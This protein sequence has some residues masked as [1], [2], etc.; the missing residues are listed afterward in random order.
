MAAR[1]IRLSRDVLDGP[2]GRSASS[3]R[4][5]EPEADTGPS[6]SFGVAEP[7]IPWSGDDDRVGVFGRFDQVVGDLRDM[8]C[9][10][11]RRFKYRDVYWGSVFPMGGGAEWFQGSRVLP[12]AEILDAIRRD[13]FAALADF[14]ELVFACRLAGISMAIT[15][16][17]AGGGSTFTISSI[18]KARQRDEDSP[19]TDGHQ[20]VD[21]YTHRPAWQTGVRVPSTDG[22]DEFYWNHGFPD[23]HEET[24]QRFATQVWPTRP[25]DPAPSTA[26]SRECA[27]RKSLGVAAFCQGI[28]EHLEVLNRV[29]VRLLGNEGIT[30]VVTH[31]E[32]GNEL[33]GSFAVTPPGDAPSYDAVAASALEAGQFMVLLAQPFR[34]L[35]PSMRFRAAELS[36]WHPDIASGD[37]DRC[38]P[39]A[40]CCVTDTYAE[41]VAWLREAIGEGVTM[42]H[43]VQVLNQHS[44]AVFLRTGGEVLLSEDSI[45]WALTCIEAGYAW[46]PFVTEVSDVLAFGATSLVH[47][48]GFHWFH[49]YDRDA[50][51]TEAIPKYQD[52]IRIK[53]DIDLLSRVVV[54]ALATS[55][56]FAL[57]MTVG[58]VGFP[59]VFPDGIPE[60]D[61][62]APYYNY[63]NTLLQAGMLARYLCLFQ[64][65]GVSRSTWFCTY[66]QP[67]PGSAN[68]SPIQWNKEGVGTGLHND[69]Y[70]QKLP[71]EYQNFAARGAWRRPAWFTYRRVA[72]LLSL[73]DGP[74]TLFE[75]SEGRTVLRFRLRTRLSLRQDVSLG[76]RYLWVAWVDQYADSECLHGSFRLFSVDHPGPVG[77]STMSMWLRDTTGRGYDLLSLVPHVTELNIRPGESDDNGYRQ[78]SDRDWN[79]EGWDSA[80]LDHG[81]TDVAFTGEKLSWFFIRKC[82]TDV[83]QAPVAIL[84]DAEEAWVS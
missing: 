76:Y 75:N 18:N 32:L 45:E 8:G 33:N 17:D 25:S 29:M 6:E 55:R 49:G 63:A 81:E 58:A 68:Q 40:G 44:I 34:N 50:G 5:G 69:V 70:L 52:A 9:G 22:W 57:G 82:A 67:M 7:S 4:P 51:G 37:L 21:V 66:L 19:L 39:Q 59:G 13:D 24:Y 31:V 23:E 71:G 79:W 15:P 43:S 47:E 56:G 72:W 36:T 84:S 78:V 26:Y 83:A 74:G 16:F 10:S 46:P 64:A 73:A 30:S 60:I 12:P 41:R 27:R 48:V 61:V 35:L 53:E 42:G 2:S 38:W 65:A 80:V 28:A 20:W 62:R 54:E 77:I 11:I 1:L 14:T 3:L